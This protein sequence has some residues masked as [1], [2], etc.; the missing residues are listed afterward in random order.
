MFCFDRSHL[1]FCLSSIHE[2]TCK[3]FATL[4]KTHQLSTKIPSDLMRSLKSTLNAYSDLI[5]RTATKI[6]KKGKLYSSLFFAFTDFRL[7]N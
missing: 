3:Q 1:E 5:L 7:E 4:K 6:K 2:Y